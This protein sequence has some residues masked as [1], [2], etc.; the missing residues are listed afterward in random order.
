[1]Q[2]PH[3]SGK[4][5]MITNLRP[6]AHIL[7]FFQSTNGV[8]LE[9]PIGNPWAIDAGKQQ[10]VSIE[11]FH[12][13]VDGGEVSDPASGQ[14]ILNDARLK[15]ETFQVFHAVNGLRNPDTYTV[16]ED[17][18]I[19]LPDGEIFEPGDKWSTM[20]YRTIETDTPQTADATLIPIHEVTDSEAFGVEYYNKQNIAAFETEIG[21]TTF[22][23]F[24]GIINQET[25]FSTY[26]AEAPFQFWNL[27]FA[28]GDTIRFMGKARNVITLGREEKIKIQWM[29]GVGYVVDEGTDYKKV[30]QRIWGDRK[31]INTIFRDGTEYSPEQQPRLFDWIQSLPP[32]QVVDYTTWNSNKSL[33]AYNELTGKF[34]VPDDR[35]KFIR[36]LKTLDGSADADRPKNIPGGFQDDAVDLSGVGIEI[37]DGKGGSSTNT[38][39]GTGFSGMDSYREWVD[40]SNQIRFTGSNVTTNGTRPENFGMYPLLGV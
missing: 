40:G 26:G 12:Y 4:I 33:F 25:T 8:A 22:P 17:G 21:T 16:L 24:S 18:G 30:G 15:N 9:T 27:Q 19:Q 37:R 35:N 38:I 6:V 7:K 2:P 39:V 14:N 11:F 23:T 3:S 13:T 31:E 20:V 5:S 36:A 10:N 1:M 34:R 32:D 28:P 29:N